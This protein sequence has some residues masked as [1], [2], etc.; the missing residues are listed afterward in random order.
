[1]NE[2]KFNLRSWAS[3]CTELQV[4]AA[5][6]NTADTNTTVNLLNLT[7]FN[8]NTTVTCIAYIQNQITINIYNH[9]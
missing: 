7:R 2:A 3:N 9:V 8:K 6:E 1:M 4:L 5:K